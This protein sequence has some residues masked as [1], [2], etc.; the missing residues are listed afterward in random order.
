[1][2]FG[3]E[4]EYVEKLIK[5]YP[6]TKKMESELNCYWLAKRRYL[7]FWEDLI[8]K[9]SMKTILNYIQEKTKNSNFSK[10]KT[11]IIIGKTQETFIKKDLFWFDGVNTFAVFY[12]INERTQE[13]FMYDSWIFALG[14]NYRKYV[15]RIN[16]I[17]N[18]RY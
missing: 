12:L 14:C 10:W 16:A 11:F 4:I 2:T 8:E 15:R 13:I 3:T 17:L 18:K 5:E 9:N 6:L 1:M 7:I